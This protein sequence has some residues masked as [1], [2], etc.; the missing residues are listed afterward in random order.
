MKIT[1]TKKGKGFAE[2]KEYFI[3]IERFSHVFKSIEPFIIILAFV[4]VIPTLNSFMVRWLFAFVTLAV[5]V[6]MA[7]KQIKSAFRAETNIL[8]LIEECDKAIE[9]LELKKKK[10]F[11][12]NKKKEVKNE[13][14]NNSN[15]LRINTIGC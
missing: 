4:I 2:L 13:R 10:L 6:E 1:I 9:K 15:Y 14:N 3:R 11:E 8:L 7:I 12:L 5:A